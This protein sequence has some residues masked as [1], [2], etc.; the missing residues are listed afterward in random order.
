MKFPNATQRRLALAALALAAAGGNAMADTGGGATIHN[1]ATLTFSGGQVTDSVDVE[2]LT[3]AAAPTIVPDDATP[4]ANG[5][6]TY[7]ITYTITNNSNGSDSFSIV[8]GSNDTGTAGAPTLTPSTNSVTLGASFTTR[9]STTIDSDSGTIYIAAGSEAN[10]SPGDIVVINIG[11]TDFRYTVDAVR[12]GT[13]ASTTGN[14]TTAED[15]TELDLTLL[16]GAPPIGNGTVVAGT[17]VGEQQT[18]TLEVVANFSSTPGTPGEHAIY[19]EG[20]TSAN[21]PGGTPVPYTTEGV[22]GSEVTLTVLSGS[23]TLLKQARNIS[24]GGAFASTGVTA[25]PGDILEYR[26]RATPV[27]GLGDATG[28]VLA[29]EIPEHTTYVTGSTTLNGN[30]VADEVSGDPFPLSASHG[31]YG[32]NSANGAANAVTGG[33]L[34]EADTGN[35]VATVV[36]RVTVD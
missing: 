15:P 3:V 23:V 11:G 9:N 14:T 2:V 33:T 30:A 16:A 6:D 22:P 18:F 34:L 4:D 19:V 8:A 27:A 21:G 13:P 1:A 7:T 5:G 10:L 29:D 32:I 17:Q 28:A 31:G 24:T 26:I 20:N 12:A 36:F 35:D 25:R